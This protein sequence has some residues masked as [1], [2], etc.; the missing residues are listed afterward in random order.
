[1]PTEFFAGKRPLFPSVNPEMVKV[2]PM[3]A[4]VQGKLF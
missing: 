3:E 4:K 1:M 2:A